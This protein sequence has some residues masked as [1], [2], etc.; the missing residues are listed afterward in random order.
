MADT[1]GQE[2]G[3]KLRAEHI[4]KIVKGFALQEYRF[5]QLCMV[6]SSSAW[7]ESYYKETATDLS[8]T[9]TGNSLKGVPR[10]AKFPYGEVSWTKATSYMLK[11]GIEGTISWEDAMMDNIDVIAR[12]LL[13]IS[14]AIAKSVDA[15][16]WATISENQTPSAING[17]TIAAGY[18]WDS[19]AAA[20]RDPIQD[21]LN[22]KKMIAE[23]NYD[24]DNGNGYLVLSPKDYANLLGNANVRN[25]GQFYTSDVTKNGKVG[26]ILGL[27]I[28]V[29]NN[30]TAD[31]AM[32]CIAKECATWKEAIPLTVKTIDDPGVSKTIRAWEIGVTQLT[33]PQ[34]VCLI[35]N[36][37]A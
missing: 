34:A 16:I 4:D 18:E 22:A 9:G 36:T 33:N 30:V 25:A 11:H 8:A 1:V 26:R 27:T 15:D 37:Q 13:R 14:R 20:N 23:D 31:Y 19:A 32:V 12:T 10:L 2:I 24:P 17:L 28:I 35:S 7:S 5:K 6:N 21:I 3:Q 29:S